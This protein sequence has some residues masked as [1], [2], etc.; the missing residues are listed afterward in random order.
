MKKEVLKVGDK[1]KI[2]DK[3]YERAFGT[4]YQASHAVEKVEVLTYSCKGFTADDAMI[5]FYLKGELCAINI[6]SVVKQ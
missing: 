2:S 4:K 6:N 3:F 5:H 1:F